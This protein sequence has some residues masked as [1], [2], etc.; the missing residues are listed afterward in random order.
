MRSVTD[1][2]LPLTDDVRGHLELCLDCRACETAC[3][4]GVQYGRLIEP[5]RVAMQE[6]ATETRSYD[7]FH[8]WILFGLFPYPSRM[9]WAVWPGRIAQ[10]IGLLNV[11]D[12]LGLMRLLPRRLRQLARML[13]PK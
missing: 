8:L 7:W 5:F 11:A 2:K 9:R 3:P 12:R 13:P 10:S 4:S 1:D 6:T